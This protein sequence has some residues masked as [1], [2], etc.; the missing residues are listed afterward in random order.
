MSVQSEQSLENSLIKT[1]TEDLSYEYVAVK[2]ESNLLSNFK[3]QLEKHNKKQLS[4][5]GINSFTEKEFDRIVI[6]LSGGTRFDKAKKLRDLFA[7]DLDNGKRVWINFLDSSQW[8]QNEFQVSN[9]ITVEGRLQSRYDVTLLINGLPLVQVELKRSGIELKQAYNQVQRYQKT[10]YHDLFDYIQIFVISNSVN[11]RY[12]A[13]NSNKGYQFTFNWTNENNEPF[14]DLR[15]FAVSFFDK[16]Q[17]GK[18]LTKYTVLHEGF[19]A[20]MVLRP[21]QVY[22]VEKIVE[23]VRNSNKNGYI[24][25]TTGS[26]KTLTS[27]KAAQLISEIDGVDKVLFVV[28]RHDLDTQTQAEYEAFEPNAVDSTDNTYE[29]IKRLSGESKIII[30]TIQ[31]LNVAVTREFYNKRLQ[32]I[33]NKK[34]VMI[35]DECHRGH[36]GDCHRN[37]VHFFSNLQVFGFTGTPIFPENAKQDRTTA[38]IFGDCLH[39]YLIKD[40][41]ADENVLGFLVD[42]YHG[43]DSVGDTD[44][45][46]ESRMKEIAQFILANFDKSTR[47]GEFDALFAI[48]SVP[49]LIEYY[50]IFKS[51]K[52]DIKI[53][54]IFT[55]AANPSQDDDYTG[56]DKGFKTENVVAD[57]LKAIIADYNS[58]YSTDFSIENFSL[59]NDDIC[60]RMKRR[61]KG[62]E[63][64][65]LLLVVGMF[66]T[67]FDA[68]VLNT[69]YVDKNMEYHGLLQAFSRTNRVLNGKKNFG[70]IICFRDLKGNVDSAIKLFS[71][72]NEEDTILRPPFATVKKEYN[73]L[74]YAFKLVYPYPQ[75][76][77]SLQ[78]ETDKRRF[79]LAF[80]DIVRKKVDMDVYD[81][82]VKDDPDF[83]LTEQEFMDYRSKYLDMAIGHINRKDRL[84]D[85][86]LPYGQEGLEGIDFCLELL[87]SDIINVAYILSLIS[88]LN[89]SDAD[90][91][92]KRQNIIDTMIKDSVLRKK[93][94]LIDGF[95]SQNVDNDKDGFSKAKADGTIDL[96]GR[97]NKYIAY[98][99]S[100]AVDQL[101]NKEY[102]DPEP[103]QAFISE[104]DYNQKEKPE[105]LEKAVAP[106]RLGLKSRHTL[107]HK[108]LYQ[109]RDII[110]T[111]TIQ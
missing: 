7:F 31:K 3:L 5:A 49:M 97:L 68:Q 88:S 70:K 14:N 81:E 61:T 43:K 108:L 34:V 85:P 57:D 46:N 83:L 59:Y 37:I 50:K 62:M 19:K 111:F 1:L 38:E 104:F 15:S 95:I 99:K 20:L 12:F 71:N 89:P 55:Y 13:N 79:V 67:G 47:N 42:Y 40:A 32:G 80:R 73:D 76:V 4:E 78:S 92:S 110:D 94:A 63:N 51:L 106:K 48:Q 41:I 105:L 87:H 24:W 16:C 25:H 45:M 77:D 33:R 28:D 36:F 69:L 64:L 10:S 75:S 56:L 103:L 82:Y 107:V 35:F 2:E 6:Y 102:V 96:E 109:L 18:M 44:Y 23:R 54:A 84:E 93:T 53:G 66:L 60:R 74:A 29:L 101:A 72:N 11:T 9:Q 98:M 22:A 21:Y 27:F 26:G 39:R 8:C 100:Q 58:M 91:K 52:P 90:Y 30:T 65:D 17:L 86:R